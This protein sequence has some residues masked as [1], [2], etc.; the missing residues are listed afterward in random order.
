MGLSY[1]GGKLTF[2]PLLQ[3]LLL[4]FPV[5]IL[6]YGINDAYDYESDSLNPRKGIIEG[7]KLKPKHH[8]FVKR[9]SF[10]MAILLILS[11]LF[12]LNIINVLG[13]SLLVFFGYIYSA[14]PLRLKERPPLDSFSNGIIYFFAPFLIGFSFNGTIFDI[15]MKIY[16][17]TA[18]VMGIHAFCTIV[19]YS[20]DKKV[21][22]K[23]FATIFGKRLP[24]LFALIVFIIAL[25]FAEIETKIINYYLLFCSILFFIIFLYPKEKLAYIFSKLVFIGF[26]IAGTVYLLSI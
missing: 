10:I 5:C 19:D 22:D 11:S 26:L 12:S 1:S 18:C 3:I 17:I 23:T 14:P 2:L 20:A 15:P 4:S 13:M 8:S 21:G 9:T 25:L 16:A 24:S 7:I 6:L